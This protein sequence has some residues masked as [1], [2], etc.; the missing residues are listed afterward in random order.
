M[1]PNDPTVPAASRKTTDLPACCVWHCM[2]FYLGRES[3]LIW[4][5]KTRTPR[6]NSHEKLSLIGVR[7]NHVHCCARPRCQ[8]AQ[9]R[10]QRYLVVNRDHDL[11]PRRS[12]RHNSYQRKN[13]GRRRN[14]QRRRS[15][16][17]RTLQPCGRDLGFHRKHER[18]AQP[19]SRHTA[20]QWIGA[21]HGWLRQRLLER[22]HQQCGTL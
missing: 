10:G 16:L 12:H 19:C 3:A 15:H 7:K 13:S 21:G 4:L 22:H 14:Q 5:P 9:L 6:R 18:G 11:G 1:G 17:S 20:F 2:C 8:H